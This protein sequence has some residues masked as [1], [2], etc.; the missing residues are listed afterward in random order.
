MVSQAHA[1]PED[2]ALRAARLADVVEPLWRASRRWTIAVVLA[3][4]PFLFIVDNAV[5]LPLSPV[6]PGLVALLLLILGLPFA[7]AELWTRRYRRK[8]M[9]WQTR[10]AARTAKAGRTAMIVAALWVGA[11]FAVGT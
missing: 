2:A 8:P 7:L 4:F 3:L 9:D 10:K 11:W 5:E 1:S 6:L